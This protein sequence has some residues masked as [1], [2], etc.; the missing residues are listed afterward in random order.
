ME[1]ALSFYEDVIGDCGAQGTDFICIAARK[2]YMTEAER[3]VLNTGNTCMMGK[4]I[5]KESDPRKFAAK[6]GQLDSGMDFYTDLK[7]NALPRSCM[8]FYMNVNHTDVLKAVRDF[9]KLM[10]DWDYDLAAAVSREN[11]G[12]QLK[13][14]QNN[15]LKA[16]QDPKN[17]MKGWTDIDCDV[18]GLC[19]PESAHDLW[20][21]ENIATSLGVHLTK[22][23][24]LGDNWDPGKK[25]VY[26]V[27]TH[28]GFHVLLRDQAISQ[29]NRTVAAATEHKVMIPQL[30]HTPEKLAD[31][32]KTFLAANDC[33]DAKEIKVNQNAA[34]PLPGTTQGGF[35][36]RLIRP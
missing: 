4:T 11:I 2:K 24:S 8:V 28:G 21:Q 20:P 3:A 15:L 19:V 5:L 13:T 35:P 27:L 16:F 29:H 30:I 22:M 1:E 12:R 7:G 26:V 9:K 34:V 10:V 6:L 32:I 18:P 17:Q 23:F 36:V 31:E 33:N 25:P 14:V